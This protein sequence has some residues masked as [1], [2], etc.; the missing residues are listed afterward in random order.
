MILLCLLWDELALVNCLFLLLLCNNDFTS[1]NPSSCFIK[2]YY[3]QIYFCFILVEQIINR[4]IR[5]NLIYAEYTFSYSLTRMLLINFICYGYNELQTDIITVKVSLSNIKILNY[6]NTPCILFI[7]YSV[8][9]DCIFESMFI[10]L[11][12]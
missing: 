12:K 3:N 2:F 11:P 6:V 7:N 1:W 5:T 10:C 8:E 9:D 4:F